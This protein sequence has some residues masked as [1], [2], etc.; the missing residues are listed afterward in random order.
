MD[1]RRLGELASHRLRR[2]GD[3]PASSP[4]PAR[5]LRPKLAERSRPKP[6]TRNRR[7]ERRRFR[8]HRFHRPG[9]TSAFPL[10]GQ[11][12]RSLR[13]KTPAP[14]KFCT[15]NSGS[16]TLSPSKTSWRPE[17]IQS[18]L[19]AGLARLQFH[20]TSVVASFGSNHRDAGNSARSFARNQ[21]PVRQPEFVTA[22]D[23]S[24]RNAEAS[25]AEAFETFFPC[26]SISERF[27]C[28]IIGPEAIN[29]RNRLSA[30]RRQ[31]EL[32]S[33]QRSESELLQPRFH[34]QH[35]ESAT[36]TSSTSIRRST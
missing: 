32:V 11:L 6:S 7:L 12:K 20:T 3:L 22:A 24:K 16:A 15:S 27:D 9:S 5:S 10:L 13:R 35:S 23:G 26:H 19:R 31:Q 21:E 30:H 33:L 2:P 8:A 29:E 28:R 34:Q 18:S 36:F 1:P 25:L 17:A 4:P 14:K